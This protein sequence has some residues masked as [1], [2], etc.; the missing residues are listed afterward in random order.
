MLRIIMPVN[1][2]PSS[3]GLGRSDKSAV[4]ANRRCKFRAHLEDVVLVAAS[5][6][7]PPSQR[8]PP[9]M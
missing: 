8:S 7:A 5:A 9:V 3:A 1:A 2:S 6:R 4:F